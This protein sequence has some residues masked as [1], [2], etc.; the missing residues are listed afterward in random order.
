MSRETRIIAGSPQPT[1][2]VVGTDDSQG[3]PAGEMVHPGE[4]SRSPVGA[5]ITVEGNNLRHTT[6]GVDA[7]LILGHL[8]QP[9]DVIYLESHKAVKT[10]QFINA[11]E[12]KD[13]VIM[14]NIGY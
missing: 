12:T 4:S 1:F 10:F 8:C 3:F 7:S 2:K 9:G 14:V 6:G 13:A 11:E 5:I